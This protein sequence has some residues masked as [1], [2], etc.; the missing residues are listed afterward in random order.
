[1]HHIEEKFMTKDFSEPFFVYSA[2]QDPAARI[3][4]FSSHDETLDCLVN[5]IEK[6]GIFV[7]CCKGNVHA[8]ASLLEGFRDEDSKKKSK[9]K[10]SSSVQVIAMSLKSSADLVLCSHIVLLDTL[11]GSKQY[12]QSTEMQAIGRACRQGQQKPATCASCARTLKK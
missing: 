3:I 7:G 1:V 12:V 2:V 8:K 5:L 11:I 6:L 10:K 9:R 4:I